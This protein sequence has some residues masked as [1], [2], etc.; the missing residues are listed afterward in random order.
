MLKPIST[1]MQDGIATI[2]LFN[3]YPPSAILWRISL[4]VMNVRGSVHSCWCR[5]C[6]M[7]K[8]AHHVWQWQLID[9][10]FI[11]HFF[12]PCPL[13]SHS[14][15]VRMNLISEV[16]IRKARQWPVT[17]WT[18]RAECRRTPLRKKQGRILMLRRYEMLRMIQKLRVLKFWDCEWSCQRSYW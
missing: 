12:S 14:S 13:H 1:T 9:C 6:S 15:A 11:W 5:R 18:R 4:E 8:Q 3:R 10:P 2:L 7:S 16:D 17:L